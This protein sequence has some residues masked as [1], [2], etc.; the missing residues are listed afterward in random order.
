MKHLLLPLLSLFFLCACNNESPKL[1]TIV[2]N[3]QE[4][5]DAIATVKPGEEIVL[6]N[7]IWKD[8]VIKFYG[9]GTE[10]NPIILR[11]ETPGKVFLEG[12][13]SLKL[14][15]QHLIVNGLYFRNGFTTENAII[16]FKIDNKKIAYHSRVTNCVIKDFTNPDRDT[17]NHWIE[18]WGQ[19]NQVD[20]N[21]ITGKTNQ[22]PTLRVFLKGNENVNTYHQIVDNHF[23]PRPR[24]GGPR[25]ETMQI[26]DSYTSMTPG[27]VNV[28]HNYFERCNGEVEIISSKSNYNTFKN[29]VFFASEG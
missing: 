15:G 19:H 28:E 4:L 26:G 6:A 20:H 11:A 24:K 13:S 23:G 2:S 1:Q 7:G 27:Y 8:A 29:N 22:G 10:S 21:Y 3:N 9:E 14:G 17:K 25:A 12:N 16:R 18:L 5:N